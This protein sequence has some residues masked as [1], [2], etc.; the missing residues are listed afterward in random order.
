[1][2]TVRIHICSKIQEAGAYLRRLHGCERGG[3]RRILYIG[4]N[5]TKKTKRDCRC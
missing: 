3:G 5:S 1:M 2:I 4:E